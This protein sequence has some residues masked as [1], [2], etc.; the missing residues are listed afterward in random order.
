MPMPCQ[1]YFTTGSSILAA[2]LLAVLGVG[3]LAA[4]VQPDP[5]EGPA[6]SAHPGWT[7]SLKSTG[8]P[9]PEL[10][11]AEN[12]QALY[13]I[14]VRAGADGPERLAADWEEGES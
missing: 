9:G 2:G 6:V 12:G 4:A 11:L 14:V 13:R 7:N 3:S 8:R 1:A 10:H 5:H